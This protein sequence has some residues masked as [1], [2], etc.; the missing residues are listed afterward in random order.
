MN[1][2]EIRKGT[3]V[4][5]DANIILYAIRHESLQCESFL[6]RCA[7]REVYGILPAHVVAEVMHRL[8]VAEARENGWIG[9]ANPVKQLSEKP[10]RVRL[11]VRYEDAVK[12]LLAMGL[13]FESLLKEDV[14]TALGVQREFGLMTNDSLLIAVSKRLGTEAVASAD[15][16]FAS[17]RGVILYSPDDLES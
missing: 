10:D 16:S 6:R 5:V 15:R 9:G 17:V 1:I 2:R 4:V 12:S 13:R 3:P 8:M 14:V 7:E 11:L